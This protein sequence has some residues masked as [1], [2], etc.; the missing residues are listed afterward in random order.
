MAVRLVRAIAGVGSLPPRE[1]ELR[2]RFQL[3]ARDIEVQRIVLGGEV[4]PPGRHGDMAAG[5]GEH[6]AGGQDDRR[7]P[8]GRKVEREAL[9][10]ADVLPLGVFNLHADEVARR[11]R[12]TAGVWQ[13]G[14]RGGRLGV[15]G[16][17]RQDASERS[18]REEGGGGWVHGSEGRM[19]R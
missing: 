18:A 19:L 11:E 14:G 15:E 1:F 9:D 16:G 13:A 8:P 6:A 4:H 7:D 5:Q 2:R 12:R 3:A 10:L 17:E